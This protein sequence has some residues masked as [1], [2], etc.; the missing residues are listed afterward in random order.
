VASD[1]GGDGPGGAGDRIH[2]TK[3]G[4]NG[5]E[6]EREIPFMKSNRQV[7]TPLPKASG[8]YQ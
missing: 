8:R 4:D 2:K 5:D 3:T 1:A 7:S 6:I